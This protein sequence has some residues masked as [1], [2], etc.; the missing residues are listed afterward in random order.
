MSR[1]L[2]EALQRRVDRMESSSGS[3]GN[4]QEPDHEVILIRENQMNKDAKTS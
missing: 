1:H 4:E 3:G 2:G